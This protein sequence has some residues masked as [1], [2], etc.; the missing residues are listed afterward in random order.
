MPPPRIFDFEN[1]DI[2][3][4]RAF[5]GDMRVNVGL[6]P[7]GYIFPDHIIG[8][9]VVA[10]HI[11]RGGTVQ[12]TDFD[13]H[14]SG[15]VI[16]VLPHIDWDRLLAQYRNI[17]LHPKICAQAGHLFVPVFELE[18]HLRIAFRLFEPVFAHFDLQKQMDIAAEEF[19]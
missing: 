9:K 10:P 11:E 3:I 13:L 16:A 7:L 17:G 14:R 19:F 18:A 15:M 12:C 6:W 8:G 5:S 1:P 4:T 2:A